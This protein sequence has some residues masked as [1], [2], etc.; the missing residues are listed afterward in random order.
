MLRDTD[1]TDYPH[2]VD[3][4]ENVLI[5]PAAAPS[6]RRALQAELIRA[7]TDGPGVV[8]F[9]DAFS[10]D[11][12]DRASDAFSAI[13]EAQRADGSAAGDHFGKPG[14]NDRHLERRAEA[15]AACPRC[16]RRLLRQ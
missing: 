14:A 2:A 13:I 12:I 11:V 5:Y 4:R 15:R 10:A 6:D 16:L 8:V 7:L 9:E 1:L 3:V